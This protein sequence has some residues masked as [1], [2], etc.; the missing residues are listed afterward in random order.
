M[1]SATTSTNHSGFENSSEHTPP[2][3]PLTNFFEAFEED[4]MLYPYSCYNGKA[5]AEAHIHVY[6]TT[7]QAN[8][9]SKRLGVTEAN[10][11]KIAE[12]GLSLD[13]QSTSWYSRNDIVEHT[14]FDKLR[15]QFIRLFHR[16]IP[17]RDLMCQ[18]YSI[19]QGATKTLPQFVIRFQNLRKQLT[20][21]PT[22]E[23][24]TELFLTG[25]WEPP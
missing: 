7:W 1:D 9:A 18:F 4:T 22:P 8:H 11:S 2:Q 12:F 14:D 25:L 19:V 21:S 17:Q 3:S 20:R 6:P 24:L 16:R 5:D 13:G 23:E 15:E 10:M